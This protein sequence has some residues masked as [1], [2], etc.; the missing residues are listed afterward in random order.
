MSFSLE[1]SVTTHSEKL[2][3]HTFL[4]KTGTWFKNL[5]NKNDSLI[6]GQK[7]KQRLGLSSEMGR[8][9]THARARSGCRSDRLKAAAVSQRGM[10][11]ERSDEA[12][13]ESNKIW[14]LRKGVRAQG[15]HHQNTVNKT[16]CWCSPT[17]RSPAV[18]NLMKKPRSSRHPS[19]EPQRRTARLVSST[20][21]LQCHSRS[22]T[23]LC[24]RRWR[25]VV[26]VLVVAAAAET[27]LLRQREVDQIPRQRNHR[28]CEIKKA[29][30]IYYWIKSST[31][32]D[33]PT[34]DNVTLL[35]IRQ[36]LDTHF[37]DCWIDKGGSNDRHT[38]ALRLESWF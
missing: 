15:F 4:Q 3:T 24:S 7:A 20:A 30:V 10:Y 18:S 8:T 5:S 17:A 32:L 25:L 35:S 2:W 29:K 31:K 6:V 28:S 34:C 13:S 37:F 16:G 22:R 33:S 12:M 21:R 11:S 38:N 14:G 27:P 26:E 9:Q 1:S 36:I 19:H 23:Q